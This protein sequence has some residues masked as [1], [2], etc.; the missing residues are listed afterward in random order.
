MRLRLY[1]FLILAFPLAQASIAQG[2]LL[3]E[4]FTRA[5][6]ERCGRTGAAGVVQKT[7]RAVRPYLGAMTYPAPRFDFVEDRYWEMTVGP[8]ADGYRHVFIHGAAREALAG[9][10]GCLEKRSARASVIHEFA[11]I[12][13]LPWVFRGEYAEDQFDEGIMEGTAQAFAEWVVLARFGWTLRDWSTGWDTYASYGREAR[14]R[15]TRGFIHRGQFGEQW[16]RVPRSI[17]LG[18]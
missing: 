1:F 5:Q 2:E 11:H 18:F 4:R 8:G 12:Y 7:W 9:E 17:P 15:F 3:P 10:R 14:H 16:G 13:Q 6:E